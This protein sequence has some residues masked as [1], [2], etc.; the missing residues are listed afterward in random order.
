MFTPCTDASCDIIED[1]QHLRLTSRR[2]YASSVSFPLIL[3]Y[4]F[5]DIEQARLE[6]GSMFIF[7]C[8]KLAFDCLI[9]DFLFPCVE[10]L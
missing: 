3:G 9:I 1:A 6:D 4:Q 2:W 8:V 5:I 7:G 10:D